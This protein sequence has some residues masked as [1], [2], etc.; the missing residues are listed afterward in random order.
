MTFVLGD[1]RVIYNAEALYA[2]SPYIA[3][4]YSSPTN[5]T[6][7]Y[8]VTLP[9]DD[10]FLGDEDLV[11]DWP[12]GHGNET[13]AMQEQMGYWIA[14]RMNL[15]ISH[16]YTIRL[17]VNGVTDTDRKAVFEAMQQPAKGFIQEWSPHNAVGEFFKIERAFEFSD[18]GSYT[19]A[20]APSLQNFTTTGG[21]KK[22]EKYRW[23]WM[24]R[25]ATRHNNYTNL[26][27]LVDAVNSAAPEPYTSATFATVDVEEWM[28]AFALEHIIV[29]FDAYGHEIGKNMYAYRP[30]SGKW[31]LYLCDLDWLMLAAP[32]HNSSYAASSAP[33]F[34]A[35][36]PVITN[37]FAAPRLRPRLLARNPGRRRRPAH[38][39]QLQP[40]HGCQIPVSERQRHHLV[41]PKPPSPTR[42]R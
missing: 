24:F 42:Q 11:L 39:R 36:D 28:R 31:Q 41:R 10:L 35:E 33:L 9:K 22:R 17:H 37:M 12:G 16:R 18:A 32:I 34:N 20:P 23:N 27:A 7:G 29:N 25:G 40:D 2:G 30:A 26:F 38:R 8:T 5:G 6:C 3:P 4:G 15:P 19:V 1:R 14:D 21:V 13:T